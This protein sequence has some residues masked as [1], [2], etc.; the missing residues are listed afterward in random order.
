M[1]WCDR[2][3]NTSKSSRTISEKGAGVQVPLIKGVNQYQ[4]GRQ[5]NDERNEM[6]RIFVALDECN[7]LYPMCS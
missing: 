2:S 3:L 7:V 1:E 6:V 4:R 5:T